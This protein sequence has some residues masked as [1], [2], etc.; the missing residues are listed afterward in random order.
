MSVKRS[1]RAE[2][3]LKEIKEGPPPPAPKEW[4]GGWDAREISWDNPYGAWGEKKW[5]FDH[6]QDWYNP[7]FPHKKRI[8]DTYIWD[9]WVERSRKK[10][11]PW[12]QHNPDKWWGYLNKGGP[13]MK[14]LTKWYPQMGQ[15][16]KPLKTKSKKP[17]PFPKK[18]TVTVTVKKAA[19]EK[20]FEKLLDLKKHYK[21][22]KDAR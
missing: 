1:K 14:V 11:Q 18:P 22:K 19:A 15:P 17:K 7:P 21:G 2:R 4:K 20:K 13:P 3:K 8:K 10:G 12:G 16:L 9:E 5:W 6:K